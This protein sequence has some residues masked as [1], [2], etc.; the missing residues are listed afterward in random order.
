[1][2]KHTKLKRTELVRSRATKQHHLH[3]RHIALAGKK[4]A[5][6]GNDETCFLTDPIRSLTAKC[7]QTEEPF[8]PW[9]N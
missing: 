9:L 7:P 4:I 6:Q 1:M 5:E 2:N 8:D 3:W